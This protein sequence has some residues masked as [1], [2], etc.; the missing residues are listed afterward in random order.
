MVCPVCITTALVA[1]APAIAASMAGGVAALKLTQQA[2]AG[3]KPMVCVKERHRASTA[4]MTSSRAN[5]KPSTHVV[6]PQR[7]EQP[8][9]MQSA[10]EEYD[11]H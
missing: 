2:G 4:V 3:S 1:N 11:A 10:W 5:I 8:F 7:V 6:K 9:F